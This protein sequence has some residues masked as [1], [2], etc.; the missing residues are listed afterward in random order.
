MDQSGRQPAL[1]GYWRSGAAHRVR[2]AIELKGLKA[3][4][5][6]IDLR[7]GAQHSPAYLVQNPQGLVPFFADCDV[8]MGQSLAIIEYLDAMLAQPP[9]LGRS[10][11][12]AAAI[13]QRAYIIAADVH[14]LNNLRVLK[15]LRD[16]FGADEDQ[17]SVWIAR[18]IG[19]GFAALEAMTEDASVYLV[20]DAP[21]LADICLVPQLYS[22]R[23]FGV[24]LAPYPRLTAIGASLDRHPAFIAAEPERQPDAPL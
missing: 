22:A 1:W 14:P 19:A 10:G 8:A 6:A 3:E 5:V 23:R 16:D 11:R 4:H 20:G 15:A 17:V 13:R 18:W 12:E 9:L 2:I 7:T 21:S 24:D